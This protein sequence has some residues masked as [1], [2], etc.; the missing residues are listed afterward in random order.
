VS[1]TRQGGWGFIVRDQYGEVRGS[2]AG[3][4]NYVASALQAEAPACMEAVHA[5]AAWGMGCIELESDSTIL[6]SA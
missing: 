4:I 5:S 3:R 1:E 6:V 2:G